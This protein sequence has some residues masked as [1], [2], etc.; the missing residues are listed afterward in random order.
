[1]PIWQWLTPCCSVQKVYYLRR[2]VPIEYTKGR[3]RMRRVKS[4][5]TSW[6]I[7]QYYYNILMVLLVKY[8]NNCVSL[9]NIGQK[10]VCFLFIFC[11]YF[12]ILGLNSNKTTIISISG[13]YLAFH[14]PK[15]YSRT[16]H[17]R[18]RRGPTLDFPTP[19]HPLCTPILHRYQLL[20]QLNYKSTVKT[21]S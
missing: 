16:P 21:P 20:L 13:P 8:N 19:C 6:N 15:L 18:A 4:N 17:F 7:R 11:S 1:M 12:I 3:T 2:N 14:W 10:K 9:N 5:Q